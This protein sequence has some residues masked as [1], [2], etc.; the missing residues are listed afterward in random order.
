MRRWPTVWIALGLAALPLLTSAC[1]LQR[2]GAGPS[3]PSVPS[4]DAAADAEG[5][6]HATEATASAAGRTASADPCALLSPS[7]RSSAGL[8][9]VGTPTTVGDARACDYTEPGGY[10]VTITID[11]RAGLADLRVA[12]R[13]VRDLRIGQREALLVAD[14]RADDGTCAVLL[15]MGESGSVH[16]DVSS[17]DFRDTAR[18]CARATTVAELI[19]PELK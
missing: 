3:V 7:A 16:V 14:E 4:V 18:A 9:K 15:A 11:E 13:R 12:P 10:G 5:R 19:E 2:S 1:G 8:T 6:R 17:A